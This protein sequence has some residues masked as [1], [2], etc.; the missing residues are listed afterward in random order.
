MGLGRN[1]GDNSRMSRSPVLRLNRSP[2]FAY[3]I[4]QFTPHLKSEWNCRVE[5]T[6]EPVEPT[7][8]AAPEHERM[9]LSRGAAR[10]EQ[11]L[12]FPE[13]WRVNPLA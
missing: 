6:V 8:E 10:G 5:S 7:I 1:P 3:Y 12:L 9:N 4:I 2:E 11:D 13:A